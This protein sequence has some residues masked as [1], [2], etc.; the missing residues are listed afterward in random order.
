MSYRINL[1]R[2]VSLC[3]F[4]GAPTDAAQAQA[5]YDTT[6]LAALRWREIGP[7]R[8]GRSVA[9]AG[10]RSRL[11]EYYAGTTGGGVF[12]TV[13]GGMTW[14]P[15]TDRYF[16][17]TVGAIAVSESIRTSFMWVP[18]K[19]RFAGTCRT[20]MA[21]SSRSM[22]ERHGLTL[23]LPTPARS[24]A[25]ASIPPI[26]RSLTLPRWDMCGDPT[27]SVESS[28]PSTAARPGASCSFAETLPA[29]LT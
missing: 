29:P 11:H 24:D 20:A 21:F 18:A 22:Q 12:K 3:L 10:S 5:P 23:G 14:T 19:R 13:D 1:F 4:I 7:F 28:R 9:V 15:V 6:A 2:V 26:P 25:F 16:G 27:R 17:G 8:G